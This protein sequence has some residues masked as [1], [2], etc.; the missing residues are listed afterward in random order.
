MILKY[1][2]L[3]L[4][5]YRNYFHFAIV[6]YLQTMASIYMINQALYEHV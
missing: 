1:M 5:K 3:E 6:I 2:Y 4:Y